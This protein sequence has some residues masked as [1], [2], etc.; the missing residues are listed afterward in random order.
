LDFIFFHFND[1][2]ITTQNSDWG[3]FGSFVGGV[4]GALFSFLTILL[5]VLTLKKQNDAFLLNQFDSSFFNLLKIQNDIRSELTIE[6][7]SYYLDDGT[8]TDSKVMKGRDVFELLS[9]HLINI[10]E[11]LDELVLHVGAVKGTAYTNNLSKINRL[12]KI[13]KNMHRESKNLSDLEKSKKAY[14]IVFN[15]HIN[16]IGHYFRHLF[17]ILTFIEDFS[18]KQSSPKQQKEILDKYSKLVQAQLSVAELLLLFYNGL[19]FPKMKKAINT[20][21]LIENLKE[22]NLIRNT[23]KEFYRVKIKPPV[24]I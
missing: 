23:H 14:F 8:H 19:L 2:Q 12:Y 16:K 11:S 17:N 10:Y 1:F 24:K 6:G 9:N 4:A 15:K 20:F 13:D 7:I 22:K 18:K 5:L 21:N 3:N